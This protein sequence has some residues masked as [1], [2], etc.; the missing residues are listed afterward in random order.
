MPA[1]AQVR[2][3]IQNGDGDTLSRLV[4]VDAHPDS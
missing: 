1:T 4:L 3:E 2:V